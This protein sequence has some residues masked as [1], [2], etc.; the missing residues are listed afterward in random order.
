MVRKSNRGLNKI[1]GSFNNERHLSYENLKTIQSKF[2][3]DTKVYNKTLSDINIL[4]EVGETDSQE[5]KDLIKKEEEYGVKWL[6]WWGNKKGKIV[7]NSHNPFGD[8]GMYGLGSNKYELEKRLLF[9]EDLLKGFID[10][11][12]K[13]L[14]KIIEY[15]Q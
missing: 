3:E 8:Y 2:E 7:R 12:S 6:G 14:K 9:H 1:L 4:N 5:Y 13:K 11:D 10:S 15:S